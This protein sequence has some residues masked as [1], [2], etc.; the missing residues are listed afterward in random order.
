MPLE[1]TP[2]VPRASGGFYRG[3]QSIAIRIKKQYN[4]AK[5]SAMRFRNFLLIEQDPGGVGPAPMAPPPPGGGAGAPPMPPMGGGPPGDPMAGGMPPPMGG[6]P[7]GGAP[8]EPPPIPQYS[9]VWDVL[10][11]ILNHKSLDNEL[12][13][14]KQLQQKQAEPSPDMGAP[15][16]GPGSPPGMPQVPDMG[17]MGGPPPTGAG[18]PHLMS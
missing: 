8:P 18:G 13:K 2:E 7:G 15:P 6:P 11:A 3:T 9:D 17:S 1:T 16:G 5:Y 10:D 12:A 4:S 14:Q